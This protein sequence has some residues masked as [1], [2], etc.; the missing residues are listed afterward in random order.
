MNTAP[1]ANLIDFDPHR[2][3]AAMLY[4]LD[5]RR[6][7]DVW[8]ALHRQDI[9]E[10][11]AEKDEWPITLDKGEFM[12]L[13][14]APALET[15]ADEIDARRRLG[16]HIGL[17]FHYHLRT[18]GDWLVKKLPQGMG[19]VSSNRKFIHFASKTVREGVI[20]GTL[21]PRKA[22]MSFLVKASTTLWP[23]AHYWAAEFTETGDKRFP[24]K[25]AEAWDAFMRLAETYRVVGLHL[26]IVRHFGSD[27]FDEDAVLYDSR[28][29]PFDGMTL[30]GLSDEERK[31]LLD[32]RAS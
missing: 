20:P 31:L 2:I 7:E 27:D 30:Q 25:G 21:L 22:S 19:D 18:R 12:V 26:G 29:S 10:R 11:A 3:T 14:N 15:V 4:P 23:A 16:W 24:D 13:T 28:F 32:Y 1:D 17:A 5:R 9:V 6:Q 8:A